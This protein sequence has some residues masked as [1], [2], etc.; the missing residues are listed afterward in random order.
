MSF[1]I[2]IQK[3]KNSQGHGFVQWLS[4][5][6]FK[7]SYQRA[8]NIQE[9]KNWS[10]DR[11][12]SAK[13]ASRS[14]VGL[15]FLFYV[16]D[17]R[18]NHVSRGCHILNHL[19]CSFARNRSQCSAFGLK[20]RPETQTA[21]VEFTPTHCLSYVYN[22]DD[23][24]LIHSFFRSSNVWIFIYSLSSLLFCWLLIIEMPGRRHYSLVPIL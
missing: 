3:K 4:Y 10:K 16:L 1:E 20:Y 22:C 9:A 24:S 8:V 2:K 19:S 17:R 13:H 6:S 21:R 7:S 11:N 12:R 5:K 15:P 18:V 23:H 14:Y